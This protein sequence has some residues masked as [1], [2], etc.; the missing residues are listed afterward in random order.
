[1]D[2]SHLDQKY[3]IDP[4]KYNCPFCKRNHV[5][6]SLN[7]AT[8]FALDER[9]PREI[10]ELIFEDEK[11]QQANLL[12]GASA[13]LRKAIYELLVYEKA[14]VKNTKSGRADYQVSIKT[15]KTK[16]PSVAPEL[17]DALGD[18]QELASDNVHEGTREAW[19]SPKLRF[20]I[21]L[22]KATLH[23]IYVVPEERKERLGALGQ[24]KSI[25]AN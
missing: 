12:V 13:C 19:N 16:F 24:M 6:Y 20:I 18:I 10:R 23:E 21:E 8:D 17:F 14:V 25:F 4:H 7:Q 3:F 2:L 5:S 15:F 11:S 9:I 22:A 1:M